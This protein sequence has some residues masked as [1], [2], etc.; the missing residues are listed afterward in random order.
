MRL[1]K[2]EVAAMIEA[3]IKATWPCPPGHKWVAEWR[4]YE[5]EVTV[6]A[7]KIEAEPVEVPPVE[8]KAV[9]AAEKKEEEV[10]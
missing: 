1:S 9:G 3:N 6:T 2:L 10:F 5:D 7:V 4:T 8:A